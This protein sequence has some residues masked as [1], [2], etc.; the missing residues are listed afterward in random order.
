[1]RKPL[2]CSMGSEDGQPQPGSDHAVRRVGEGKLREMK[3]GDVAMQDL[4]GEQVNGG[5]RVED[6]LAPAVAAVP[7]VLAWGLGLQKV[8]D[9]NP[10]PP[11]RIDQRDWHGDRSAW[12]VQT[13]RHFRQAR[14]EP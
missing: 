11:Q 9:V 14:D 4:E 12:A 10:D 3:A 7:A 6:T 1:M 13:R 2:A 8:G 5:H